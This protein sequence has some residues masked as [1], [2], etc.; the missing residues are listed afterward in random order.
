M[1]QYHY[2]V[3]S[4]LVLIVFVVYYFSMPRLDIKM[5]HTFLWMLAIESL[6][7]LADVLSSRADDN[8]SSYPVWLLYVLNMTFFVL[9]EVRIL[10]FFRFTAN[11]LH[12]ERDS[13]SKK[14]RIYEIVFFLTEAITLS[15]FFT[16]AVFRITETGYQ[17]G[18][19]YDILYLCFFFYIGLSLLLLYLYHSRLNRYALISA[20]GY[21]IVLIIGNIFRILMPKYLIMNTFCLIGIIIIYLSFEDPILFLEMEG[22]VF[23]QLAFR[24]KMNEIVGEKPYRV[25]AFVLKNY[26]DAREIYGGDQ[27][28]QG[29]AMICRYLTEKYPTQTVFYL[30]GGRFAILGNSQMDWEQMRDDLQSRFIKTWR[31]DYVELD[32]DAAYVQVGSSSRMN[33]VE[34]IVNNLYIALDN[35]GQ[36]KDSENNLIDLDGL[37]EIDRQVMVK[38]SLEKALEEGEVEIF[39]QPLVD[40]KTGKVTCAEALVRIRDTDGKLILPGEFISIAE[41][42]GKIAQMGEQVFERTCRFIRDYSPETWGIQWINVNLSPLQ[43]MRKD[44]GEHFSRI[45]NKYQVAPDKIHLEITEE[46]MIDVSTLL[47]QIHTLQDGGFQ[48]VLDDYGSGYSNLTRVKRYPFSNI[49]LDM[50]LVWDYY[51]ERDVLLPTMIEAFKKMKFS[52]TAEGIESKE[53]ADVM[54]ELGCDYLQGFYFSK[55]LPVDEFAAKYKNQNKQDIS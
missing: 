1:F 12:L 49:K 5:N 8:F 46:S 30:R 37:E 24:E 17:R 15:S 33:T 52:V 29:I 26:N 16:G 18:P 9:F 39:L 40:A 14:I 31:A 36:A 42:S 38:R 2:I 34:R 20:F 6:I 48:F 19:L 4:L 25:F 28:D 55:P 50:E 32:L 53:M 45:L 41:K 7:I 27:M 11:I 44:L 35:A 43:C 22:G 23:N 21:N 54:V 51:K 47:K 3:P 10:L 13:D